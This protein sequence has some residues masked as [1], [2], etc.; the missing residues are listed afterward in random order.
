MK[1]L[2]EK[3]LKSEKIFN[4]KLIELYRDQ[5]QLPNGKTSTR[6]W[7]DHPG[8]A[9]IVPIL[10]D[11]KI[12]LVKQYRYGPRKEFYEIP[13]GKLDK[14]ESP[15][16]CA[17]RE[18]LEE[19]G[20]LAGEMIFLTNVYPAIGFCNE[21]MWIYYAKNLQQ[22]EK[23]LDKDEFLEIIHLKFETA[24]DW[25][26]KGKIVDVKTIIGILWANKI[27]YSDNQK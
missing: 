13:A 24:L 8:A 22:S 14:N 16:D 6:E 9:C 12:C 21:K 26:W 7:I 5:V 25:V 19:T 18:L 15:E 23:K 2:T 11:G 20:L 17:R 10:D 1:T 27:I 4:G 3:K